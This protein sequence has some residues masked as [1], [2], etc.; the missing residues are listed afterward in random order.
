MKRRKTLKE[1]SERASRRDEIVMFAQPEH[2]AT[3]VRIAAKLWREG[4]RLGKREATQ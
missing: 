1:R 4:Y 3:V 2:R